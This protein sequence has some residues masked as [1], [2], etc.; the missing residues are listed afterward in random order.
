MSA[1]SSV[2]TADDLWVVILSG[3][4]YGLICDLNE[5]FESENSA[6]DCLGDTYLIGVSGSGGSNF[7]SVNGFLCVLSL[8]YITSIR[9][10]F[11][12]SFSSSKNYRQIACR[13]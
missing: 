8:S 6:K 10:V 2:T 7:L 5:T 1:S 3:D 12:R 13:D 4:N 11:L 9:L